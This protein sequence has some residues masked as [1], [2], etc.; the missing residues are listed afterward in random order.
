MSIKEKAT[1]GV[2]LVHPKDAPPCGILAAADVLRVDVA[3][4]EDQKL[5]KTTEFR[6]EAR[7]GD[8]VLDDL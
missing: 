3:R 5:K 8:F 2:V 4:K 6:F 1:G 7:Y